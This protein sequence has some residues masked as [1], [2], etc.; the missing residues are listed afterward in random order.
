MLNNLTPNI[1]K[2]PILGTLRNPIFWNQEKKIEKIG[3]TSV[4]FTKD[5][6]G[7]AFQKMFLHFKSKEFI[8]KTLPQNA[9]LSIFNQMIWTDCK[10]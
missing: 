5:F 8:D 3:K 6:V 7:K 10:F 2:I 4:E 1:K 9:L